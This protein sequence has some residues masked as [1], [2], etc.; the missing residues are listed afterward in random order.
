MSLADAFSDA[1]ADVDHY[2]REAQ[3]DPWFQG[4]PGDQLYST[5]IAVRNLMDVTRCMLDAASFNPPAVAVA[6]GFRPYDP[7]TSEGADDAS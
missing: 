2:L 6:A 7:T 4:N 5:V 3:H 1:V